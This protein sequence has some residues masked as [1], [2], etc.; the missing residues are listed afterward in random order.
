M[1]RRFAKH[2]NAKS[3]IDRRMAVESLERRDLL[4]SDWQ[5]IDNPANVDDDPGDAISPVDALLVVNELN[6]PEFSD[7]KTGELEP[8]SAFE[9]VPPPFLDVDGDGFVSPRDAIRVINR[10]GTPDDPI[11]ISAELHGDTAPF[12]EVNDDQLT[13]DPRIV[14]TVRLAN[15][16]DSFTVLARIDA[17]VVTQV[18]ASP[19]GSFSFD[20]FDVEQ[21]EDGPHTVRLSASDLAGNTAEHIVDFVLDRVP[22]ASVDELTLG[23][24]S[25]SEPV[26]D[27]KTTSDLVSLHGVG[28]PGSLV[29]L[30]ETSHRTETSEDGSFRFRGVSLGLGEN[31]WTTRT[32]D[33][34]GN[35]SDQRISVTRLPFE[36]Y[37]TLSDSDNFVFE[38]R[39]RVELGTPLG[40]R[41]LSF[42]V[43]SD[44]GS[45]VA[46]A[47][48]VFSVY[49]V[50]TGTTQTLLDRQTSGTSLFSLNAN[51]PDYLP[52]RVRFD[53]RTVEIDVSN[54]ESTEGELL[55]QLLDLSRTQRSQI[56]VGE[57][58]NSIDLHEDVN[59]PG[60]SPN[61][62]LGTTGGAVDT[63]NLES[64]NV[65]VAF[66]NVR[67]DTG[68]NQL[69]AELKAKNNGSESLSKIAIVF[70]GLGSSAE[71]VN[72]SGLTEEGSPYINLSLPSG[73]LRPGSASSPVEIVVANPQGTAFELVTH[74]LASR[75]RAPVFSVVEPI[76]SFPGQVV[77]RVAKCIGRRY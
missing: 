55:F 47:S 35:G 21:L 70:D 59:L 72:A 58:E 23:A 44:F 67:Y 19:D 20:P 33:A 7:P 42:D 22:P 1:T 30:V 76:E 62:L 8:A 48:D 63:S 2:S 73:G 26:G 25:D 13:F 27:N 53:G 17:G 36:N 39:K 29:E 66:D 71:V 75:N 65:D 37:L 52:G 46:D 12:G 57:I 49:L 40:S 43:V 4:A 69:T 3:R 50:A 64:S 31:T 54:V 60:F 11:V 9:G 24:E 51:E 68:A 5:N 18:V 61:S 10:I 16:K 6:W 38:L 56:A 77:S 28:E 74:S 32:Y 15:E 14:G 45:A 41:T 34:A